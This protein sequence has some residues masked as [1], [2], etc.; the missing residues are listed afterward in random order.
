M[1]S[2]Y[3]IV[4]KKWPYHGVGGGIDNN[5]IPEKVSSLKGEGNSLWRGVQQLKS[6]VNK[7]D[8]HPNTPRIPSCFLKEQGTIGH[9][10]PTILLL[11]NKL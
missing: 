6:N 8:K 11:E 4:P 3:E 9:L 7:P 10:I 2:V 5:A 1:L